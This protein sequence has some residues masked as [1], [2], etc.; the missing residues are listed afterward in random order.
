[1]A[2]AARQLKAGMVKEGL[3]LTGAGGGKINISGVP[4]AL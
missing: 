2:Q 1:M 3:G 4:Q